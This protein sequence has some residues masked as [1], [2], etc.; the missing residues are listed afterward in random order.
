MAD[1]SLL[2]EG[3]YWIEENTRID[4]A[5]AE[6]RIA[7]EKYVD[8]LEL[9]TR[10]ERLT[11]ECNKT[12]LHLKVLLFKAKCFEKTDKKRQAASTMTQALRLA[13]NR[14]LLREMYQFGKTSSALVREAVCAL[15]D[16]KNEEEARFINELKTLL[17]IDDSANDE[18]E[19]PFAIEDITS[20]EYELLGLLEKGLKNREIA[21]KMNVSSH[22]IAW[23]LKNLYGKLQVENR[24]AAVSVARR[25]V[26]PA[27]A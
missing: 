5:I 20:R 2:G 14:F 18:G 15:N 19:L 9:L 7:Q 22:T 13:A 8:A 11:E 10:N 1:D 3:P 25:I 17:S 24:T 21:E 12:L 23:H 26:R 27:N 4:I 16:N 6:T